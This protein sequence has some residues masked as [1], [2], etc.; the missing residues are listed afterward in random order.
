MPVRYAVCGLLHGPIFQQYQS[1]LQFAGLGTNTTGD[2]VSGPTLLVVPKNIEITVEPVPQLGGGIRYA[3]DQKPNQES[4]VF[5]PGGLYGDNVLICGHI[6]TIWD[7][8]VALTLYK[9]FVRSLTRGFV[10]IGSYRVGPE[11]EHFMDRGYRM[12]TI[13]ISSPQEY[14]LRKH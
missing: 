1:L 7:N 5:S 10:K 2:H 8:P 13:G 12:V 4:I 3:L 6:G 11:A 9:T 14:D